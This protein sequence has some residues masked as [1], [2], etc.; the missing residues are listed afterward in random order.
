LKDAAEKFWTLKKNH[1]VVESLDGANGAN[2]S[3]FTI[4][5]DQKDKV[6][7]AQELVLKHK[8]ITTFTPL[9]TNTLLSCLTDTTKLEST[10]LS[11]LNAPTNATN[12]SVNQ[13]DNNC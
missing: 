13:F 10:L 12:A 6:K 9:L 3:E 7:P 1:A 11:M 4:H 8:V 5:V 2:G